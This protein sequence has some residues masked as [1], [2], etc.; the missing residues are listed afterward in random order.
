MHAQLWQV[1]N[2]SLNHQLTPP[3]LPPP[4]PTR[5]LLGANGSETFIFQFSIAV[6]AIYEAVLFGCFGSVILLAVFVCMSHGSFSLVCILLRLW[7]CLPTVRCLR[8]HTLGSQDTG[9]SVWKG[10]ATPPCQLTSFHSAKRCSVGC[11]GRGH[12]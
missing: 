5:S 1:S 6:P 4:H 9:K 10:L 12:Q 7:D 2:S 3:S 11:W 8:Q